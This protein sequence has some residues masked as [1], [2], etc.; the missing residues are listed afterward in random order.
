MRNS[1]YQNKYSFMDGNGPIMIASIN[2]ETEPDT[3]E[4]NNPIEK[5]IDCLKTKD[6][7]KK[8]LY[9]HSYYRYLI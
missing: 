9:M 3:D 4:N 6:E 8:I 7:V 1:R 2:N 5:Q